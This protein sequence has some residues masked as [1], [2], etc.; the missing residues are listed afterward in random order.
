MAY[1]HVE[2]T[3]TYSNDAKCYGSVPTPIDPSVTWR[4]ICGNVNGLRPYGD[5][6]ARIAVA[7]ILRALQEGTIAF[8]ETHVE[9]HTYQLRDNMQKLFIKAFCAARMEYSTT[10]DKFETTYH[11]PGGTVCGALVQ[12]VHQV[13]DSGRDDTECGRWS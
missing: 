6:T 10:S 5:M 2:A 7:E 1:Q 4:I 3:E 8:S 13:V 12:M 9:W 11:K